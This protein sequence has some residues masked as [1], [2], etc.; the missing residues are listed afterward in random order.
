[1]LDDGIIRPSN[2]E[3]ASP[4]VLVKKRN[5]DIKICV[6]FRKL[7]K[8]IERD[9]YPLL[10]IE[11]QLDHLQGT[12]IFNTLNLKNGF[13][14]VE[15][16]EESRKYTSFIVPTGQY[17][18]IWMPFGLYNSSSVFQKYKRCIQRFDF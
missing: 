7:N 14:H 11:D 9:Y 3:Y 10:L 2:S 16:A 5:G 17:E 12:R 4:I 15:I 1:V 13:F 6:E 8:K 18:F